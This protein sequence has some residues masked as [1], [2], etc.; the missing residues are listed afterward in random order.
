MTTLLF[1]FGVT[2]TMRILSIIRRRSLAR[3]YGFW[4]FW[5]NNS[6]A[7]QIVYVNCVVINRLI[8]ILIYS[9]HILCLLMIY[10]LFYT[11]SCLCFRFANGVDG[12][13]KTG[14]GFFFS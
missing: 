5:F 2:T 14:Q 3:R 1:A 12:A 11:I 10:N 13:T 8:I 9:T 4:I 7:I 6:F